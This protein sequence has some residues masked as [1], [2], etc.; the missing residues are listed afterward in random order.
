MAV[1]NEEMLLALAPSP[2]QPLSAREKQRDVLPAPIRGALL[3]IVALA[4]VLAVLGLMALLE[5]RQRVAEDAILVD[6]IEEAPP[7]VV[8]L[9]PLPNETI[10]IHPPKP[11]AKPAPKPRPQR[12]APPADATPPSLDP[13]M[14]VVDAKPSPDRG[15][16][17]PLFNPDGSLRV[18]ADMLD[19]L[20]AQFGDK[21]QFSWQIPHMDDAKKYFDR[22][23]ALVY[24]GTRFDKYWT[25]EG[26]ALTVLLTKM[27]EAT[28]KQVKM[29]VPGTNGSYMVCTI[30]ILAMGGGCGVLTNGADWNGPQDDPNTLNEEEERQCAAWWDKITK[31]RTQEAWR[32]TKKLYEAACRK[33]LLHP[34]RG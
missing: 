27:V 4:H 24:E 19:K 25:P 17:L 1:W 31:A 29:K 18:P 33:P 7:T 23:P 8:E 6:F 16:P 13:P 21:R 5:R 22:N 34:A 15:K 10:T 30:S 11:A 26:D 2:W 3:G 12:K 28:T 14:Q 9:P 20:D 32:A